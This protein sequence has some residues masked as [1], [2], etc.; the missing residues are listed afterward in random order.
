MSQLANTVGIRR[1][2]VAL[3][4]A[5][6]VA[7][8]AALANLVVSPDGAMSIIGTIGYTLVGAV[9]LRQR[10]RNGI[11]RLALT[12]GLAYSIST[13]IVAVVVAAT[14]TGAAFPI[15]PG[16]VMVLVELALDASE[17]LQAA[18][19]GIGT[20]L[21]ITWFPSGRRTSRLGAVVEVGVVGL[22]V[23]VAL[24]ALKDPI[25]RAIGWSP[26]LGQL[27]A[28]AEP[29]T[30]V[31]LVATWLLAIIDLLLRYRSAAGIERVQMSWVVAAVVAST[32]LLVLL[33][34]LG[35]AV[36]EL[37]NLWLISSTLPIVAVAIAIT[38]Y[39]LYDIDR[40]VSRSISYAII[41]AVLFAVFYG[42]NLVL[43]TALGGVVGDS[44]IVVAVS[45]LVVAA[46]FAP[47]RTRVQAI[48][49][50]RFHR[51]RYDTERTVA[52]YAER[53]REELDLEA[54]IDE[55][56]RT[57]AT[58]VEPDRTLVWLRPATDRAS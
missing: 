40:I 51:A 1:R 3:S 32:I 39:R 13:L 49:D 28:I 18:A 9:I 12:I 44:P 19:L 6:G 50:R 14:P 43:Q 33:A 2:D 21:L 57:T 29:L 23:C 4:A 5:V 38:R 54:L 31:L 25:L 34:P 22:A 26:F 8:I 52:T 35:G 58:A 47:V 41:T 42:L 30:F 24:F 56:E 15:V 7:F 16:S 48:V 17:I 27:F 55:L 20:I 36:P 11:G 53:L 45:T 37:W 10:P 46:L